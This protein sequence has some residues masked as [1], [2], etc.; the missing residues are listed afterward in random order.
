MTEEHV[1]TMVCSICG[2]EA[3]IIL[4][5]DEASPA[6]HRRARRKVLVCKH[7]GNEAEMTLEEV[8]EE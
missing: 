2:N 6:G 8:E 5:E 4:K 3:D 7:C 1:H